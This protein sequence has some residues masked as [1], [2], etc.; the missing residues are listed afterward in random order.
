MKE[1]ARLNLA[2]VRLP[3]PLVKV[4]QDNPEVR[5]QLLQELGEPEF[6]L[7]DWLDHVV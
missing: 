6:S 5:R 7:L 3:Q 1:E 2:G 4:E